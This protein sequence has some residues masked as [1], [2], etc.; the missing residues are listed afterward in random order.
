MSQGQPG[1]QSESQDSQASTDK[2]CLKNQNVLYY[3]SYN[4]GNNYDDNNNKEEEEEK[5][6]KE[7]V[8]HSDLFHKEYSVRN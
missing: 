1:L 6:E 4:N 8:E 5:K 7:R 2:P 3:D